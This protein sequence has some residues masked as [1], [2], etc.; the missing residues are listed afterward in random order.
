MAPQWTEALRRMIN[1]FSGQGIPLFLDEGLNPQRPRLGEQGGD[2]GGGP[3]RWRGQAECTGDGPPGGGELGGA[4]EGPGGTARD[5]VDDACQRQRQAGEVAEHRR[6]VGEVEAG[7]GV[8][9]GGGDTRS[10]RQRRVL[11]AWRTGSVDAH[12]GGL[13]GSVG[14]P[15]G[16]QGGEPVEE[17]GPHGDHG[18]DRRTPAVPSLCEGDAVGRSD[19]RNPPGVVGEGVED[20]RDRRRTHPP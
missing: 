11:P 6:T 15:G 1:E 19:H 17:D 20:R 16:V 7:G 9:I 12:G 10:Q 2:A 8:R 4:V 14:Q 3:G 13:D 18:V 5:R